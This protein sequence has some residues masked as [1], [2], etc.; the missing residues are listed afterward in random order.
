[1]WDGMDLRI[2][3]IIII[4]RLRRMKHSG[5]I[6]GGYGIGMVSGAKNQAGEFLIV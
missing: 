4:T 1:M 3:V 2:T 5:A 6:I